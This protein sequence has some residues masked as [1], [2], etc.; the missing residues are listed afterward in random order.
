MY[1]PHAHISNGLG[2]WRHQFPDADRPDI[3]VVLESTPSHIYA[4]C[5]LEYIPDLPTHPKCLF[6]LRD[7][8]DQI[9]SLHGYFRNNWGWIPSDMS[10]GD[11]VAAVRSGDKDFGGNELAVNALSNARYVDHL[12]KW[13]AR[14]GPERMLVATFD[15]LQRNGAGLTMR[16][17]AWLGL[18]PAF[19]R[20]YDFPREN[21]TYE[22]RNRALQGVNIA[23][24]GAIPRGRAHDILRRIYRRVNT[25]RPTPPG[26]EDMA[27][28]EA[29]REEFAEANAR[30]AAEFG[31]D[32]G[33]WSPTPVR[34][35]G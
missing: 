20:S 14:L 23:L 32:T 1:K 25:T 9:R 31:V 27:V 29:L 6:I 28:M 8:A 3:R 4:R 30:L 22:P 16:I 13:R 11:Y 18:D 2:S 34:E 15:E 10:F 19:Y 33:A 7:P 26:A 5:A 17:A 12:L 35:R 21:E 24:R